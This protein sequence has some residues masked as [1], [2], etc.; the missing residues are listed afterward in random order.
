V[1]VACLGVWPWRMADGDLAGIDAVE[2]RLDLM[3]TSLAGLATVVGNVAARVPRIIA[4][5]RPGHAS[6]ADRVALLGEAARIGAWGVDIEID[7]P[8]ESRA[9]VHAAAR[10]HGRCL[11]VS[12]HDPDRTPS[13]VA[14]D[15]IVRRAFQADADIVKIAC[16]VLTAADHG[17]LLGLLDDERTAGR[18]AVVGMGPRGRL[19]RIV[20]PLMGSPLAYVS[21]QAGLETADGQLTRGELAEAWSALGERL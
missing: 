21:M 13:R 5:C 16:R 19:T 9:A 12:H 2:L 17:A 11:I 1:I 7:A 14:L 18:I 10:A 8:A 4:T 6:E 15:E 3:N 20:A